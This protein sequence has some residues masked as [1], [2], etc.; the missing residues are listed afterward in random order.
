MFPLDDFL[1]RHG[2][3]VQKW[4]DLSAEWSG[5][6][7]DRP[8]VSASGGIY[9]PVKDCD[10]EFILRGFDAPQCKTAQVVIVC[11]A[12]TCVFLSET[13]EMCSATTVLRADIAS[14]AVRLRQERKCDSTEVCDE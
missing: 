9:Q 5:L 10:F 13:E 14:G 3:S 1:R 6:F 8:I 12:H 7:A 4:E 11:D 2:Q